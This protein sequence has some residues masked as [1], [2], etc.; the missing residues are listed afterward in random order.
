[1]GQVTIEWAEERHA[2]QIA[3]LVGRT[4]R[5]VYPRYYL[6]EIVDAFCR[7]HSA[8]AVLEDIRQG[9][10]LG[11]W[12]DGELIGTGTRR[13]ACISRVYVLPSF[14]GRGYGALLMDALE[15]QAAGEHPALRLDASL[16]ACQ[17][18]EHRGYRTI[19]HERWPVE[20]G[21]VPVYE[22]MEK[23]L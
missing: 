12:L 18:Y 5:E 7:L 17:M 16:P 11:L 4:V 10:V 23:P 21:G 8:A 9:G 2:E 6:P 3:A 13:G 22:I 15:G 14:Q 19:R 1:M 20:T